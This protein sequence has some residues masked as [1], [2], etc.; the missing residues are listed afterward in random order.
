MG[1]GPCLPVPAGGPVTR[2]PAPRLG[3]GRGSSGLG[4]RAWWLPAGLLARMGAHA[5]AAQASP[6]CQAK[7]PATGPAALRC[8][9]AALLRPRAAPAAAGGQHGCMRGG[10]QRGG[11]DA[12]L[13]PPAAPGCSLSAPVG[14]AAALPGCC[15]TVYLCYVCNGVPAL[16]SRVGEKERGGGGGRTEAGVGRGQ[17]AAVQG[18][19]A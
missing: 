19:W 3:A 10:R 11:A 8:R 1:W 2:M 4:L 12:A 5:G 16:R 14:H 18:R 15:R 6:R 9:G 13:P 7:L 17:L